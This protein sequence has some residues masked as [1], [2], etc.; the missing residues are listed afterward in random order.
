[1]SR[2]SIYLA[3][4]LALG[5]PLSAIARPIAYAEGTTVT[6]LERSGTWTHIRGDDG[7]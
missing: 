4:A 5:M 1:M 7:R 6:I 3:G 2:C